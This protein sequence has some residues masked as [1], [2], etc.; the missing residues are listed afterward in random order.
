MS[1]SNQS[2][3]FGVVTVG[4][5]NQHDF[6]L[7]GANER[8]QSLEH[9]GYILGNWGFSRSDDGAKLAEGFLVDVKRHEV[10]VLSHEY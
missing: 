1:S 4:A 9:C 7:N 3:P 2:I 6:L 5:E 10:V 8:S